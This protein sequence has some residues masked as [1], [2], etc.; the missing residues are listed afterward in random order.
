M[1]TK[2]SPLRALMSLV[3]LL[4]MV[5]GA[6]NW[7]LAPAPVYASHTPNPTSV[8]IAGSLQ[9]AL[10]CPGAWDPACAAAHLTYDAG[11]DVWQKS[12]TVPT[13]NWEYKAALNDSWNE[14]YGL[15]AASGGA[16]IPLNLSASTLV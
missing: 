2:K 13:G 5:A 16:N 3:G 9:P 4:A 11:D 6:F 14:N 7:G 10:G 1:Y 12:W 8:T 15:N